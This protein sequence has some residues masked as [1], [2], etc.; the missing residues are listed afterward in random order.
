VPLPRVIVCL[1]VRDGRVVKGV[2]FESLRDIGD[3]AELAVEYE[4]QGADEITFLDINAS[5]ETRGPMLDVVRRTAERLFVPLAVGGGIRTSDDIADV[6]RA[7]ADKIVINTAGVADP[8]LY[9]TGARR[10]GAQCIVASV[11]ARRSGSGW[12]VWTHGARRETE[13][14]AVSWARE[15]TERGAGEVLV[16][17]IDRDGTRLGY[18]LELTGAIAAAVSVPV[19]ASGG[20]GTAEHCAE[21]LTKTDAQAA[22]VAGVLH[23]GVT[24]VAAIKETIAA[25]GLPV[26]G[27][28]S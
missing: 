11:D 19:I 17:S 14:D 25:H 26:R 18:D 15:C 16:T 7:G 20:A 5:A 28:R 8:S 27:V 1:D 9:S 3:P 12:R 10:F 24:T 13:H 21:V 6:L 22:L 4:R 2:N 23:D